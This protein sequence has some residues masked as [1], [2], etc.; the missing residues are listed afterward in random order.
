VA[1]YEALCVIP[2]RAG[3]KRLPG[4]NKRL[5]G[6]KPLI[7]YSIEAAL[8]SKCFSRIILSTDDV[9][10]IKLGR[11]ITGIEAWEREARLCGD[12]IRAKDVVH[13]HLTKLEP[14]HFDYVALFMPTTPF[15]TADD[16]REA[17]SIIE[18]SEGTTLV[19]VVPFEF[20]PSMALAIREERLQSYFFDEVEWK[21]EEDFEV[22]YRPNG[23]IFIAKADRFLKTR[24]FL[25]SGT[26][27]Y[28]MK[29][30]SSIDIDTEGDL[31][32]AEHFLSTDLT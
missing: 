4:K 29:S 31:Q 26:I 5:L 2:A 1:S 11:E 10:I 25:E 23:A 7:L 13:D 16:V 24:T 19:S 22:A 18:K 17:F 8:R 20:Q 21:R 27:P 30:R 32:I 9:D 3:S 12:N 28:L 6:G 14:M 15:R